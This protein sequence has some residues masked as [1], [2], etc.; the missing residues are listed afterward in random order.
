MGW[1][2]FPLVDWDHMDPLSA[3]TSSVWVIRTSTLMAVR[4]GAALALGG[5]VALLSRR[6]V[7]MV[8]LFAASGLTVALVAIQ[9]LWSGEIIVIE[10]PICIL[11]K[12]PLLSNEIGYAF[13]NRCS[14]E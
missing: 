10:R 14:I 2:S 8:H 9:L 11:S 1:L 5:L 13:H 3:M 12:S 4:L 7:L 6:T